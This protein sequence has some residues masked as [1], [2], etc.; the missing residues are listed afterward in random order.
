MQFFF[1]RITFFI[2][3]I[4]NAADAGF[5][6]KA[7]AIYK[8][9]KAKKGSSKFGISSGN[10]DDD[11]Q[12]NTQ[13]GYQSNK[14]SGASSTGT[15][16]KGYKFSSETVDTAFASSDSASS[17]KKGFGTNK[18]GDSGSVDSD[19]QGFKFS[20]GTGESGFA[21][22]NIGSTSYSSG[23][24]GTGSIKFDED[25]SGGDNLNT[26]KYSSGTGESGF[27]NVNVGGSS[28]SSGKA[29][30]GSSK[31]DKDLSGDAD[32][33]A[34]KF[35]SGTGQPGFAFSSGQTGF[36]T[37]KFDKYDNVKYKH[38]SSDGKT[39]KYSYTNYGTYDGSNY[40]KLVCPLKLEPVFE[41]D[42]VSV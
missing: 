8:A 10:S 16:S 40:S 9:H 11:L 7:E 5:F 27:A 24:A 33:N 19:L 25:L 3:S 21:S 20:S 14:Y 37:N 6:K 31:F 32:L 35:S 29:E 22:V 34:Y 26:Y 15:D 12:F 38:T 41:N 2:C 17:G 13:S 36:G 23:K 1:F 18:F 30:G 42:S 4:L 28:F 39:D